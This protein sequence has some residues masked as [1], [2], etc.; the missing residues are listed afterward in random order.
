MSEHEMCD[1]CYL[2][3][4]P[5]Q[6]TVHIKGHPRHEACHMAMRPLDWRDRILPLL[7]KR[8]RWQRLRN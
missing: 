6:P 2:P 1:R 3:C 5:H 8:G 7:D 4:E